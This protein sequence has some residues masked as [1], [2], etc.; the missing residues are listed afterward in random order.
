MVKRRR[1]T[2]RTVALQIVRRTLRCD[3][4]S[5]GELEDEIRLVLAGYRA[6]LRRRETKP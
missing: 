2:L 5:A 1:K 3:G 4:F 6:A